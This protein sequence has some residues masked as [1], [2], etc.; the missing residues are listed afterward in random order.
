MGAGRWNSSVPAGSHQRLELRTGRAARDPTGVASLQDAWAYAPG[1]LE[2]FGA[3]T[4]LVLTTSHL[5]R[6][7]V[8]VVYGSLQAH[9]RS[10][11]LLTQVQINLT[12]KEEIAGVLERRFGLS[13][14]ERAASING[15]ADA[16]FG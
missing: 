12:L 10:G 16:S 13:A 9:Q 1:Q 6:W 4:T 8:T 11:D 5:H 2:A 7:T 14:T 3:L 15:Y